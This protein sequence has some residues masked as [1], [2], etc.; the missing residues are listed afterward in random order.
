[1]NLLI[2]TNMKYKLLEDDDYFIFIIDNKKRYIPKKSKD[3]KF[4]N[5]RIIVD[6]KIYT[7]FLE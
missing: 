3:I 1:M 6:G 2:K 5:S 4:I 7:D